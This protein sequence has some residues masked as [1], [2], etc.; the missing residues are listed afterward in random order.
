MTTSHTLTD[1]QNND[2]MH[3]DRR[4]G[5]VA[6]IVAD[7]GFFFIRPHNAPGRASLFCHYKSLPPGTF[8]DLQGGERV[9]FVEGV[10]RDGRPCATEVRLLADDTAV[11]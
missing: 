11:A 1:T 10:D 5:S 2:D 3:T 9:S 4:E 6:R 8:D 7:R